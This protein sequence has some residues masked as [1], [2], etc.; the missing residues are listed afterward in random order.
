M[1]NNLN[2][3]LTNNSLNKINWE[4]IQKEML[5]T[6]GNDIY[7]SWLKKIEF[8]EEQNNYILIS[9]TTRFIRDW[10]TSRYLDQILQIIK[11]FNKDIS[12]IEFVIKEKKEY[13]ETQ[14][15]RSNIN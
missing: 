14:N 6:F 2:Q 3:H 10:I 1:K 15:V 9:V 7:E 5:A 8:V 4:K 12:R 11:N 13:E